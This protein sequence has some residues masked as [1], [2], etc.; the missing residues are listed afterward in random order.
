M[1]KRKK[2]WLVVTICNAKAES[3]FTA[4]DNLDYSHC[5]NARSGTT[6]S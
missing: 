6:Q 4:M 2:L 3:L 1:A 5:L